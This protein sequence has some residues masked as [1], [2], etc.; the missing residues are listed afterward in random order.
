MHMCVYNLK[1]DAYKILYQHIVLE[2]WIILLLKSQATG[3]QY[4][5][6][7]YD[8]LSA[9]FYVSVKGSEILP[10][11]RLTSQPATVS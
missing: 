1:N 11:S 4:F 6:S 9:Q 2:N 10:T 7:L 5:L 3:S 8:W